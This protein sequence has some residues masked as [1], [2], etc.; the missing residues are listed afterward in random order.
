LTRIIQPVRIKE[1]KTKTN[2]NEIQILALKAL[3][4]SFLN[5]KTLNKDLLH[6]LEVNNYLLDNLKDPRISE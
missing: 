2:M 4:G 1:N 5:K 3:I 6:Q